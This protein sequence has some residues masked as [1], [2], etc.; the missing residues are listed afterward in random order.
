MYVYT[1]L[2]NNVGARTDI[3]YNQHTL[4]LLLEKVRAL[5]KVHV[6]ELLLVLML[7]LIYIR[8]QHQQRIN[9]DF[10][11]WNLYLVDVS[12]HFQNF[13]HTK[14]L[15][16]VSTKFPNLE[17]FNFLTASSRKTLVFGQKRVFFHN[18][19]SK[20]SYFAHFACKFEKK[21]I[22]FAANLYKIDIKHFANH[23]Y[24][25]FN[26]HLNHQLNP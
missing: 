10:L 22:F 20:W 14:I 6:L 8:Q 12:Q 5:E 1:Y 16:N 9:Q 4:L 2:Y 18:L 19:P 23:Q 11:P 25:I 13:F 24:Y 7:D 17:G 3:I 21:K 26:Y 15:Q